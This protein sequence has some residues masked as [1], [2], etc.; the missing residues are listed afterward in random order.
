[1]NIL[2]ELLQTG[3]T[4]LSI[5]AILI[6]FLAT[7]FLSAIMGGTYKLCFSKLNYNYKFNT[8]LVM[9]SFIT[10]LLLVL[11]GQS[12]V[13]S[14]GMLG[15]LALVRFRTNVKD[16][17]DIGFIFWSIAI[18][19]G[20]ATQNFLIILLGS[21]VI[22]IFLLITSYEKSHAHGFLLVLRGSNVDINQIEALLKKDVGS[23]KI[24]AKNILEDSFELVYEIKIKDSHENIL[25]D[26]FSSIDSI[27]SINILSPSAE[28][29]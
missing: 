8:T 23:F 14:M 7:I 21:I 6:T 16:T 29:I 3:A 20:C 22:A 15:I 4:E 9:I 1:M 24:S 5:K 18:G 27:D 28:V 19:I 12:L 10:M 13:I 11:V 25:I 2:Q 17:R 26:K